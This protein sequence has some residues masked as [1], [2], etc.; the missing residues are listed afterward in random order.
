MTTESYILAVDQGTTSSRSIIFDKQAKPLATAQ[1]ELTQHYP[2]PGWVE[3]DAEDIWRDTLATAKEAISRASLSA[4]SITAI[5]ITNQRETVVIWERATG[6][7]VHKAIVWQ[8]R[9]TAGLC[10][11]LKSKGL[12]AEITEKTG[13]LLDPYFSATKIAWILDNVPKARERAERG[14][15]AAGT[16]ESYLLFRFTGGKA[17]KTDF[18]NAARTLLLN[19]HTGEW[20]EEL[21]TLFNIPE[22]IL[23]SVE[24]NC[25]YFGVTS[26]EH[27]G[28]EIPI[29]GMAGDQQAALFGQACF[30]PGM[31]KSTYGTGCFVLTN[32]GKKATHSKNRLL[33]TPAYRLGGEVTYALEGSIFIAGAGVQW[34]RDKL[35]I[36]DKASETAELA[37]SVPDNNGVYM[38]PAFTGLGAPHWAPEAKAIICGLT[39]DSTKA[40]IARAALEAT[41]YQTLDLVEAMA[42]DYGEQTTA[43]RVDGGMTTNSWLCQFLADITT[44]KVD[45]PAHHET[46]AL[47]AAFLAGLSV[48]IWNSLEEI[49]QTWQ[50]KTSFKPTMNAD[51]R[52]ALIRGWQ[53]ALKRAL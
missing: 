29:T 11:S 52:K 18:T 43:L 26:T 1:R 13:L 28:R 7:P 46:T 50:A 37:A 8:D 10:S 49:E 48:G 19:I 27:F 3:H 9:R 31:V 39:L 44:L 45:K 32:T 14:E 42:A 17:H 34:L 5:G 12:E 2:N 53:D 22:T 40:H 6:K 47:G 35:G 23:P 38:V 15:L 4:T 36:I 25:S 24:D 16:M 20:D 41:A 30:A 21:L 33:T 51:I